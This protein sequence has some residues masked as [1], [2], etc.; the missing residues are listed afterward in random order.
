MTMKK[1]ILTTLSVVL[2]LGMAALGILAY[3]MDS[4]SDVN[5]M[6]LGNVDIEQ[7]EQQVAEDGDS[8]EPFEQEKGLYPNTTI[9]KIVSVKNTGASDCYV[10]TLIAF[11]KIDSNT[12]GYKSNLELDSI[13][14]I[15]KDGVTYEV[16][17]Y[18]YEEALVAGAET[19]ASLTEVKLA[20]TCTNEDMEALGG[21]YEVLVFSQAIQKAGFNSAEEA[22]TASGFTTNPW[23]GIVMVDTAAELKAAVVAGGEVAV[24][25]DI[26]LDADETIAVNKGKET[27][28]DLNNFTITATSDKTGSNRNVFDANGGELT[29]KDGTIEYGHEGANMGWSNSTNVFNVTNGGIL[30]IENATVENNGGSD[31]AFA[32]HLNNWGE[33][34][35]NVD[36]S[37]LKSTYMAVRVFNSGNDMNNVTIKNSTLEG[38]KYAFWVHNYTVAD[39]GTQEKADKQAGL[40]NFDIYGNGNTFNASVA[41][42]LYGFTDGILFDA[43]GNQL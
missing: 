2:I 5:V 7:V 4:D 20:E 30:N 28:L 25:A 23:E 42:A 35:L 21:T 41:A 31:M 10:R 34:T 43:N 11:E 40:L 16:Y 3:L 29:V 19:A 26:T 8:L 6:T 38:A 37:T 22:F 15:T 13:G 24:T 9:S 12:F 33:V 18:L 14:T 27:V 36:N 39:F 32:V 1:K 17:E